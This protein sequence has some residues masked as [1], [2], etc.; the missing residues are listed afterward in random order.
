MNGQME[1]VMKVN[2]KIT[3]CKDQA[4]INGMMV[5]CIKVNIRTTKKMG[6]EYIVGKIN[7]NIKATGY[8]E[9]SMVWVFTVYHQKIE[10][11]LDY[12]NK[13]RELLNGLTQIFR[14]K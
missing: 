2:G 13:A 8:Q 10:S 12:G 4:C 9:N 6:M 3:I 14:I 5:E 1:E 11:N 7:D